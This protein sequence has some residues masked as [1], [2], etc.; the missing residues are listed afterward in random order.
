LEVLDHFAED[1]AERARQLASEKAR[2]DRAEALVE[3]WR[4]IVE[5]VERGNDGLAGMLVRALPPE[6]RPVKP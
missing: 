4:P 1:I 6:H 5:A 2:A 3:A